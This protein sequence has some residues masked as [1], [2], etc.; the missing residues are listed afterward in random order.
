MDCADRMKRLTFWKTRCQVDFSRY[1]VQYVYG[2]ST[3]SPSAFG[4]TDMSTPHSSSATA[5]GG[6]SKLVV[7]KA[8]RRLF[9]LLLVLMMVKEN[10]LLL[11]LLLLLQMLFHLLLLTDC[12]LTG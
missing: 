12:L 3:S 10:R 5:S 2:A 4:L 7:E 6:E 8:N 11:V 1:N 9:L